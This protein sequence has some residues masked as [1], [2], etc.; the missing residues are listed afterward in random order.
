[1]GIKIPELLMEHPPFSHRK[2]TPPVPAAVCQI[3]GKL[4]RQGNGGIYIVYY[5]IK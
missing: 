1:M 4:E 5:A 2:T 3:G